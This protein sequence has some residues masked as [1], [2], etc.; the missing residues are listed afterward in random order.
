MAV[1]SRISALEVQLQNL[2]L[3][4][5]FKY[6]SLAANIREWFGSDK[7]N[8]VTEFLAQVEQCAKVSCWS[9]EDQVNIIKAKLGGEDVM[10]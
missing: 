10:T 5:R 6:L 8:T 3:G 1:D 2:S 9:S 7:G 4:G